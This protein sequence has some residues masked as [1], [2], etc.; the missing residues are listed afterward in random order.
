M[1]SLG[2]WGVRV[3]WFGSRFQMVP[4]VCKLRRSANDQCPLK[5][6]GG[7]VFNFGFWM[8]LGCRFQFLVLWCK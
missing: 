6:G 5:M 2:V 4:A 3:L 8:I 1:Y 7:W